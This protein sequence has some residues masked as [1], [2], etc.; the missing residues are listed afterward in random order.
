MIPIERQFCFE[1]QGLFAEV[2]GSINEC[3][4]LSEK[5]CDALLNQQKKIGKMGSGQMFAIK[6]DKMLLWNECFEESTTYM[7]SA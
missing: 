4:I 5:L 2:E 6:N 1:A 7:R 3:K